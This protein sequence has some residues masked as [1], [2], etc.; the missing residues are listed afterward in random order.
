MAAATQE[1]KK[2]LDGTS[3]VLEKS[4]HEKEKYLVNIL[5]KNF[6]VYP[7]VF[8][9]KY[10]YDTEFFAQEIPI[11]N[12][13]RFLEIGCGTGV[14]SIFAALKGASEVM[15]IDINPSAV[16]NTQEN[17]ERHEL[18]HK[19]KVMQGNVY[20][21]LAQNEKFD[22]I[23]SNTPFGYTER[24]ELSILERATF[25]TNYETHKKIIWGA[26][27]HL[28]PRGRLL[29]G[30]SRTLGDLDLLKSILHEAGFEVK[31]L[32]EI[33]SIETLPV[34]FDLY[35]AKLVT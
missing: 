35:E 5:G 11:N 18:T 8:S 24:K 32:A 15:A 2:Y 16:K 25:D 9:P 23:F 21:P 20:Q 22:T 33:E 3:L 7:N 17:I 29:I 34:I 4:Q 13:E 10:F 31:L 19:M 26:K 6:I 1:K 12:G 27:I 14:L 30:Y 28:N